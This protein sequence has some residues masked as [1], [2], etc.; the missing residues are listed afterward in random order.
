MRA[1]SLTILASALAL[2]ATGLSAE[3][4]PQALWSALRSGTPLVSATGGTERAEG[5]TLRV[6]GPVLT[7]G[8]A[9]RRR[10]SRPRRWFCRP[11]ATAPG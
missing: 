10:G 8:L 5:D 2:I 4:A 6:E 1:L 11:T 9:R 3:I 7:L